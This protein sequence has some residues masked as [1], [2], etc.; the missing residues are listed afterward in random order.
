MVHLRTE[1][2]QFKM[3]LDK[4]MKAV[5]SSMFVYADRGVIVNLQHINEIRDY[6]VYLDNGEVVTE[7]VARDKPL[8]A[9]I[10][11]YIGEQK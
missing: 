10:I 5:D 7:S 2:R 1:Q 6:M 9:A 11:R 8:R 3:T 4:I